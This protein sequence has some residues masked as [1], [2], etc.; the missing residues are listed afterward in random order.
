ML[1]GGGFSPFPGPGFAIMVVTYMLAS[2]TYYVVLYFLKRRR[3]ASMLIYYTRV[4]EGQFTPCRK[5]NSFSPCLG[6]QPSRR[7]R[8]YLAA[9]KSACS[10]FPLSSS[11]Y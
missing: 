4:V 5:R 1:N 2:R 3:F 9:D 10:A 11:M 7:L 8:T 6:C